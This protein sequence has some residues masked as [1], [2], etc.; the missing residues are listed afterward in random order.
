VLPGPYLC[1]YSISKSPNV[2]IEYGENTV[3]SKA[4]LRYTLN[5][6]PQ[7]TKKPDVQRLNVDLPKQD[8]TRLKAIA[9]QKGGNMGAIVAALVQGY[10][11]ENRQLLPPGLVPDHP[12]TPAP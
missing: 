9:P 5:V 2:H 3:T 4:G 8:H 11:W 6:E 1:S 7:E 10:I 12:P